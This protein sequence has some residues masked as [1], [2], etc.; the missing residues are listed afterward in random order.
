MVHLLVLMVLI[1]YFLTPQINHFLEIAFP[2]LSNYYN[3]MYAVLFFLLIICVTFLIK[4]VMNSVFV[5]EETIQNEYLK[6]FR[7]KR[8]KKFK[9]K[10]HLQ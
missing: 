2:T 5:K 9:F 3:M 8:F 10:S 7:Y 1:F 6:K 4:Y